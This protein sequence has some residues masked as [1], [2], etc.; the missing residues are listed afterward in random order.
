VRRIDRAAGPKGSGREPSP[1]RGATGALTIALV[2]FTACGGAS[3]TGADPVT[4]GTGGGGMSGHAGEPVTSA[5]GDPTPAGGVGLGGAGEP[6]DTVAGET[7]DA[8]AAGDSGSFNCQ[9]LGGKEL[10]DHCYVDITT[11]SL[12][13]AAAV[14]A[15]PALTGPDDRAGH[16]LVLDSEEE[17]MFILEQ[18]LE[19]LTDVSDAWLGLSCDATMYPDLTGCYCADCDEAQL[20]KKRGVWRWVD[21]TT[22]DFGWIGKNPNGEGRCS[23]LAYNSTNFSWGWVDRNCNKATHQLTGYPVHDYRVICELE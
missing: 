2:A 21:G 12:P 1:W 14:A 11:E 4:G 8:G 16:L 6:H 20:A 18:F 17:Q 10:A 19:P 5:G 7:G 3:F 13:Q 22:A 9:A 15:C 23:A